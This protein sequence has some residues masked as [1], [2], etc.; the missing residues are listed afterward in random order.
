MIRVLVVD[1]HPVV[2]RGLRQ[3]LEEESDVRVTGEAGGAPEARAQLEQAEFD[4]V[5]LDLSMPEVQGVSLLQEMHQL[6]PDLGVLVLSIHPEEQYALRCLRAGARGYVHKGSAAE[7]L[8][9]AIRT[10]VGGR[11]YLSDAFAE[12]LLRDADSGGP[13]PH[14]RLSAREAQVLTGIASGRSVTQIAAEIG[15]SVKTVSTYRTRM[16]E[17]LGIASNAEATRYAL[18][19]R[20]LEPA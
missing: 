10:V 17:K 16:L 3:V 2:R 6:R 13:A 1:D 14:E 9:G 15:V 7:E 12:S 5:V 4:I 8:V 19:H 18:E 20:L 11:R